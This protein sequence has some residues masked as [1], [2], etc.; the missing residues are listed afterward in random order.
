MAKFI[1]FI[2]S[3]FLINYVAIAQT[4][5]IANNATHTT[6]GN[7]TYTALSMGNNAHLVVSTGNTLTI[8]GTATSN[9]GLGITVQ[10]GGTLVITGCLN[11]NNNFNLDIAG[12]ITIG[13]VDVDNNGVL[14][15]EGTGNVN[16]TGNLTTGTNSAISVNLGG[17]LDVGGSLTVGGGSSTITVNG[18]LTVDGAYSGP[19]ATGTGSM[20]T[21]GQINLCPSS[22]TSNFSVGDYLWKGGQTGVTTNWSTAANWFVYD[23]T[24]FSLASTAPVSTDNVFIATSTCYQNTYFPDL[25]S[26]TLTSKN[27]DI[28]SG[29]T[30]TVGSGTISTSDMN[31]ESG[32]TLSITTGTINVTGNWTNNGTFTANST[33]TVVFNGTASQGISG[34]NSPSFGNLTLNNSNGINLSKSVTINSTLT[35]TNG[36]ITLNSYDLIIG[37][38][39]SGGSSSSFIITNST[40]VLQ[41]NSIGSGASANK[42][43]F[44][45]GYSSTSYTPMTLTNSGTIDNFSVRMLNQVLANGTTGVVLSNEFVNRTWLIEEGTVGGSNVSLLLKWNAA[46]ELSGFDRTNCN[47]AHYTNSTW[48]TDVSSSASGNPYQMQRTNITSF[49]PFTVNGSTPLSVKL[50]DFSAKI[51]KEREIEILWTT[52]T[53][54]NSSYFKIEKSIDSKSWTTI[55]TMEAAGKSTSPI[56]YAITDFADASEVIY[57]RLLQF[58]LNGVYETYGPIAVNY[59]QESEN[60]K[61]YPN[62]VKDKFYVELKDSKFTGNSQLIILDEKG[63]MVHQQDLLVNAQFNNFIIDNLELKPGMYYL[64]IINENGDVKITSFAK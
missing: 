47:V 40:G 22:F 33:S 52:A 11:G 36:K 24:I 9:N 3:I 61:V 37:T 39:I 14:T 54:V 12:T 18:S 44:P 1:F 25:S 10:S 64:K 30:L 49:S 28:K 50:M 27:I 56:N 5:T 57:Y 41:Q 62:P 43:N 21:S 46:E 60:I 8:N 4:L 32:A 16:V 35:L 13:C 34:A 15:V 19:T 23:G 51:K 63:V 2:L 17:G 29:S 31:I 20:S 53:E 26:G 59:I 7:A 38:G 45:I 55:S 6:S 48:D 42:T 58:D